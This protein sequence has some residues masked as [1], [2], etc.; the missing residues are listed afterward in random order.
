MTDVVAWLEAR[1][2]PDGTWLLDTVP[3]KDLRAWSK[4]LEV[5]IT[6]LTDQIAIYLATGFNTGALEYG[7]CD[8]IVNSL[9]HIAIEGEPPDLLWSVYLAFDE[10]EYHHPGDAADVDPI[11]AYTRPMILEVLADL[12]VSGS[13]R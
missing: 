9:F 4:A 3:E 13:D 10:G 1:F 2:A 6:A 12:A 5:P 8:S 11:E 7:F